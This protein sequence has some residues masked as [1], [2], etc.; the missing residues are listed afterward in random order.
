MFVNGKF[1]KTY[2]FKIC[3]KYYYCIVSPGSQVTDKIYIFDGLFCGKGSALTFSQTTCLSTESGGGGC[4][5]FLDF[6][7][8]LFITFALSAL[9]LACPQHTPIV[10]PLALKVFA[11]AL[12][13]SYCT[14]PLSLSTLAPEG[15]LPL[16]LIL[17]FLNSSFR[18]T[19]SSKFA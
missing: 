5:A 14:V 2:P 17:P 7:P 1:F 8:L 15:E 9:L 10:A 4:H 12:P 16:T 11:L 6:S 3:S 19:L 18:S 13:L